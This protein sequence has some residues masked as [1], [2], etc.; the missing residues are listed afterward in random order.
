MKEYKTKDKKKRP[1]KN[2]CAF[3]RMLGTVCRIVTIL[4]SIGLVCGAVATVCVVGYVV[5]ETND[6]NI[7]LSK[8]AIDLSQTTIFYAKDSSTGDWVEYQTYSRDAERTWVDFNEIPENLKWAI[9]CTEDKDF[10]TS[11]GVS[12]NRTLAA[13]ADT[14]LK[15]IGM[16]GLFEGTQGA[17]TIEQQ[18]IKNITGDNKQDATRKM[19]EIFR[20]LAL[21]KVYTKDTIL[22]YYC[23]I[24]PLTGRIAGVEAGAKAYFGKHAS[25]LTL[26]ECASIAGITKNPTKYSPYNTEEHLERRNFILFNMYDQGK[27]TKAEY[28]AA[29]AQP[30]TLINTS[31]DE[32]DREIEKEQGQKQQQRLTTSTTTYFSDATFLQLKKDLMEQYGYTDEEAE[33]KIYTGGLRVYLT[34]D[35]EIQNKMDEIMSNRAYFPS[36][37]Y[38]EKV[39]SL[40]NYDLPVYEEDGVTLKTGKDSDG[41]EY[42]YRYTSTEAAM[43]TMNYNGEVIAMTGGIG[44][45]QATLGTNRAL[46]PHQTGSSI[47]PL[48]VYPLAIEYGLVNYTTPVQDSYLYRASDKKVINTEYC[49]RYGL[50]PDP[51][52]PKTQRHWGAFRNWPNNATGYVTNSN[53]PVYK[54]LA[55]S[56]NTVA[57][58]LGTYVGVDTLYDFQKNILGFEYLTENDK[59][60]GP[61]ALGGQS[62]GVTPLEE[63]AAYQILNG[64][65]VYTTPH[66]YTE[67]TDAD[68]N[69]IIDI[70]KSVDTIQAISPSTS[71][72]MNQMLQNVVKWG[73]ASGMKIK[74]GGMPSAAKTGTTNEYESLTFVGMTPY[75]VTSVWYGYDKPQNLL[76]YAG[77][78]ASKSLAEPWKELMEFAQTGLDYKDFEFSSDVFKKYSRGV[79]GFFT[80]DNQS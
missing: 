76:E 15:K 38:K 52:D 54:A 19:R 22:E 66:Y 33:D 50:N 30:I 14:L 27:I 5:S 59:D 69:T 4:A 74:A 70:N 78:S 12:F 43:V 65:G 36:G 77:I 20:A 72:I 63:A 51:E 42:Y 18:L 8:E 44:T 7:V 45:K 26:A 10:Y 57:V 29:I 40:S 25:E 53:I 16:A 62:Y 11:P 1:I 34:I 58:K 64:S 67:V 2:P 56:L 31:E 60:L 80:R 49:L 24:I 46:D 68:G 39:Y 61:L 37:T 13:I 75:Y 28:E 23:N 55:T 6:E 3:E 35:L 41:K 47:K 73:T 71:T 32:A 79:Y 48:G 21:D 9:I 17:S